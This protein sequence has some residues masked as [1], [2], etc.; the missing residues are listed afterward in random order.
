MLLSPLK[1]S[2]DAIFVKLILT[3][4]V[5]TGKSPWE[6]VGSW[7]PEGLAKCGEVVEVENKFLPELA[8][9]LLGVEGFWYDWVGTWVPK[10]KEPDVDVFPNEKAFTPDEFDVLK[11]FPGRLGCPNVLVGGVDVL[12]IWKKWSQ[13]L[14]IAKILAYADLW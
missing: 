13:K 11:E 10:P 2:V 8:K 12:L 5:A 1:S 3:G 6:V 9:I 4:D 14:V 7:P